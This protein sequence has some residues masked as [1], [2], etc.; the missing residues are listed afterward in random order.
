MAIRC[1]FDEAMREVS[2]IYFTA[3]DVRGPYIAPMKFEFLGAINDD[4]PGAAMVLELM[5]F[6]LRILCPSGH[7][8][9]ST[10][11]NPWRLSSYEQYPEQFI[12]VLEEKSS[13]ATITLAQ[14]ALAGSRRRRAKELINAFLE[15]HQASQQL[16]TRF[17]I[18]SAEV[19]G[20][21]GIGK[22]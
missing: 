4:A 16:R 21:E 12:V 13:S 18:S 6:L 22:P 20:K 5:S 2:T 1:L 8:W 9:V 19:I 14:R 17:A 3:R 11:G 10:G 15:K 7:E